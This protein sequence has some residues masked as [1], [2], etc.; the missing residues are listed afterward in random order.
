MKVFLSEKLRE[1]NSLSGKNLLR[2]VFNDAYNGLYGYNLS[3]FGGLE[4]RIS[5]EIEENM[6]KYSVY[7]CLG[8]MDDI[9]PVSEFLHPML[10]HDAEPVFNL[11]DFTLDFAMQSEPVIASVFMECGN[12]EIA[13]FLAEKRVFSGTIKTDAGLYEIS[14]TAR[15]C[16][17]YLDHIEILYRTFQKNNIAWTTINC[18]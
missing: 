1:I 15:R 17:K 10:P 8:H 3:L 7:T 16:N 2:N 14:A 12:N 6:G 11:A 9:D 4:E 13:R 18:P 5:T